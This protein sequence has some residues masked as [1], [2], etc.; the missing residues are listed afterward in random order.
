M[1]SSSDSFVMREHI[2]DQENTYDQ[3]KS[4]DYDNQPGWNQ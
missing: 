3:D 1:F 2:L 4:A